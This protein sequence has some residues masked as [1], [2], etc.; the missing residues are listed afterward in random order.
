MSMTWNPSRS[1]AKEDIS[2]TQLDFETISKIA[3]QEFGLHLEQSKQSL[4]RSRLGKRVRA[5]G[6]ESFASYCQLLTSPGN[7]REKEQFAASLTT[8]VTQFYRETHHFDFLEN[9]VLPELLDA[10][11]RGARVRFWSAGCSSGQEA[12]SIAGSVLKLCPE[13]SE[14]DFRI[15]ATDLDQTILQKAN[16]GV[17]GSE[18]CQ[19]PSDAHRS[20]VFDRNAMK[21]GRLF[22]KPQLR[23]LIVFRKLNLNGHWPFGGAFDA[24]MC[25]NVA[26]YFDRATQER[27]WKRFASQLTDSGYLFLGHSERITGDSLEDLEA[28]GVTTYRKN[29]HRSAGSIERT[30]RNKENVS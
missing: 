27:L 4:V 14:L 19:F 29:M 21:S 17:F 12:Y 13:I 24:I 26:I 3:K 25:R 23:E 30:G 15:L 7:E 8:H 1:D 5:M 18:D 10:A 2:F 6:L 11:K 20:H 16:S 22:V 28:V 9:S